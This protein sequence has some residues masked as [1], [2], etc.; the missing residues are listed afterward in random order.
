MT[1]AHPPFDVRIFHKECRSL[2]AGGHEVVLIAPA[3]ENGKCQGIQL[4]PIPCWT[5]RL[6]RIAR[7]GY[8]VYREACRQRADVYHLHDP[9]LLPVGMALRA[10]GK[11][12]IYDSHEDLPRTISY[13]SY[14]PRSLRPLV[15]RIVEGIEACACRRI[16]ALIAANPVIATRFSDIAREV[17]VIH[18]YPRVEEIQRTT[19]SRVLRGNGSLV[20]VGMRI[21]RARGVEE[22]I[23][24]VGLLPPSMPVRL[25]LVGALDPNNLMESLSRV[26]GWDR[27]DYLGPLGRAGIVQALHQARAGLVILHPEPNYLTAEPVKLFEYMCA[28]IPAIASDFPVCR[29]IIEQSKCGLLVNPLDPKDIAQAIEYLWTHPEEAD[30]MGRRGQQTIRERYNWSNE[31]KVLLALYRRFEDAG[32]P[33]F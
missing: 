26:P 18:N 11:R 2:L 13:K 17:V 15:S 27:T 5:N 8:S 16:S 10:M 1:S 6:V 7:G 30:A 23:R 22:M 32:K 31:E 20:Y 14:V 25:K 12:V 3:P 28:G 29:K 4:V 19:G 24:A 9:E 21:T 33:S